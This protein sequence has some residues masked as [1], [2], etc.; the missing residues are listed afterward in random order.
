[1][2]T[3]LG[4]KNII[5]YYLPSLSHTIWHLGMWDGFLLNLEGISGRVD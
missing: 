4:D 3:L 1:M 5:Q 2:I